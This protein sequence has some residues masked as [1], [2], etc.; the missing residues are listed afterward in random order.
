MTDRQR[1]FLI[2]GAHT[3]YR[4]YHAIQGLATSDGFPSNA[5]YGFVQT[6]QKVIKDYEPEYLAVAFDL[7]APTFRHKLYPDYKANRP[8]AP[9]DLV[10]QIP[11]IKKI[12]QAYRIPCIER[13]GYEGDDVMGTLAYQAREEGLEAVLV[14]G[15]K[16]LHQL[17]GP[18]IKVLEPRKGVMMG[19]EE[20]TAQYG[21][22]PEKLVDLFALTGDKVDNLA[23]T[24]RRG[25][26]DGFRPSAAVRFPGGGHPQGRGDREAETQEGGTGKHGDDSKDPGA[27]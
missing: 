8:P 21:V 5:L 6:L 17:V 10:L 23:R 9:E 26:Q 20:I 7:P 27:R 22:P 3:L 25:P 24:A 11:W 1:L 4:S 19:P 14:S 18:R 2:D 13:Q 15:D 16:D 12:L